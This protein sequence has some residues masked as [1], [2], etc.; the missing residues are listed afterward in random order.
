MSVPLLEVHDLQ[1]S[2]ASHDGVIE[3]VRGIDLVIEPGTVHA[4]VGESGSGKSVT[5]KALLGLLPTPPANIEAHSIKFK[6]KELCGRKEV[7]IRQL[8]GTGI[9]MIFQEPGKHLNPTRTVDQL[10]GELL[11][12]HL[13]M[14]GRERDRRSDELLEM[15]DLDPK[16]VR[17]SYPHE[18]SGGM[19]QR[20]LI[21]MAV[22]CNPSLLLADEP[23]TALDATVQKQIL[24]LLDRLRKE[25]SMAV[26]FISHDLGVV[27]QI[28]DQV[29]VIYAGRIVESASADE[30]FEH[31][32]HPYTDL[33]LR[34][35]P[36][37]ARRGAP[38]EAIP[39]RVPDAQAIPSGCAFHTRCPIAEPEC[40]RWHPASE[41]HRIG[42]RTEC[43]R[44]ESAILPQEQGAAGGLS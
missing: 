35:I 16:Q 22:A 31:P 37:P 26:L 4:L 40:A 36:D 42:H 18:L 20:A 43:R 9:S 1:V 32:L 15:V 38:L 5:S 11:H 10:L 6:G 7:D 25:L 27:Q 21:A 23:T 44:I 12:Y 34:A 2:F 29:S 17:R 33:L 14:S 3:A 41:E 30:L 13:R 19:K 39:G 8:R 28:A 24:D